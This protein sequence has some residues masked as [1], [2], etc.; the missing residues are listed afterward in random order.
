VNVVVIASHVKLYC[1]GDDF[2]ISHVA[3]L[4]EYIQ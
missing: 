4:V 1:E 3:T 2:S